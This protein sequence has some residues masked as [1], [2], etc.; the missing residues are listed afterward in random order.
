MDEISGRL[1]LDMGFWRQRA[2]CLKALLGE[3][4][5]AGACIRLASEDAGI[6]TVAKVWD[7][8]YLGDW[9]VFLRTCVLASDAM[10]RAGTAWYSSCWP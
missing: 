8:G 9:S 4:C 3:A 10:Q 1:W 7:G 5:Q 2:C 6:S